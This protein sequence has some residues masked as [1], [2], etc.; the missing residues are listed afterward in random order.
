M[1]TSKDPV[2]EFLQPGGLT[3]RT[4]SIAL[5]LGSALLGSVALALTPLLDKWLPLIPQKLLLLV[6][7]LSVVA[8]IILSCCLILAKR[9]N[10]ILSEQPKFISFYNARW[11]YD[12][13]SRKFEPHPYCCCCN[14]PKPLQVECMQADMKVERLVCS[15][16][17]G[18]TPYHTYDVYL[19]EGDKY[20]SIAEAFKNLSAKIPR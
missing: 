7:L 10:R 14:P 11:K 17:R 4:L 19:R 6:A 3:K 15:G 12:P 20:Y 1:E 2:S 18:K 13:F 5:W 16:D 8:V 9:E